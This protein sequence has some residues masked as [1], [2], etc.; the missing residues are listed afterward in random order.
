MLTLVK[1]LDFTIPVLVSLVVTPLFLFAAAVTTGGGHGSYVLAKI[2][3][4]FTMLS[5]VFFGS[6]VAPFIAIAILQFPI[7]GL[8]LGRANVK[9]EITRWGTGLLVIHLLVVL[10]CFLLVGKSFS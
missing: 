3:F 7:Y 2:L 9:G 10:A 6:I 5:T 4:P 8:L 1:A